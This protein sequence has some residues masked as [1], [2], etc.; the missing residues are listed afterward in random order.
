[1]SLIKVE[2]KNEHLLLLKYLDFERA[3]DCIT[4]GSE[5]TTAFGS[6]SLYEGIG[7]ILYGMVDGH[8]PFGDD[9]IDYSDEQKAH[10]M[11]LFNELPLVLNVIL[12]TGSFELGHYKK[13]NHLLEWV[14]Y[15]PKE[16]AK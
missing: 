11:N 15:T 4:A 16:L 2:I 10:M 14:K 13:R 8:D 7:T 5:G 9:P 3:G 6:D 1:M 12:Y